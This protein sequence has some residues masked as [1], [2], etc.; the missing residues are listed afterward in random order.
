MNDNKPPVKSAHTCFVTCLYA[1]VFVASRAYVC[2]Q[3]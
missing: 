3:K 2:R 1:N